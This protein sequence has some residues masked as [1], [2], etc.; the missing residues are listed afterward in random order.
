VR[1]IA[2]LPSLALLS[3]SALGLFLPEPPTLS[4]S[5]GL[6]ASAVSAFWCWRA[7][8][9]RLFSLFVAGAFF[10]GAVLLAAVCWQRAWRPPLR[11]AFEAA[12]RDERAEAARDGR[13]LPLDDEATLIVEG[14]LR[15]DAAPGENGALL[16]VEVDA[17]WQGGRKSHG[18]R[19]GEKL[20]SINVTVVGAL[21]EQHVVD[22]R[23]GRRV[24]MPA[25]LRQPS[26]Y[27]D[28]GVPDYERALA[29]RGVTLVGTV[30]SGALVELVAGGGW[31]NEW[32]ASG[33]AAARGIIA[34]HVGR[35]NPQSA[36][37]VSAIVIGDRS[38]LDAALQRRLQE[39]GTYHVIAISGGN[40]AILAGLLLAVFRIAGLLGRTAMLAAVVLLVVYAQFVGGGASV[41]RATLMAVVYFGARAIDHRGPPLNALAAVA[42]ILVV[43]N[44]LSILDPAFLLTFGATL[45]ILIVVPAVDLRRLPRGT[46]LLASMLVASAAAELLL[47]PIGATVF[48]RVTFAGLGLNFLAIPL[49]GVAQI[50]GMM[51]IPVALVSSPAATAI[52]WV[53][54]AG[55]AGL[56]WS[57]NLVRFVPV[58][59]WRVAAPPLVASAVYYA[60]LATMWWWRRSR[61]VS[62]PLAV[63]AALWILVSPR[64]LFAASGDGRL[65]VTFFDV[66]QGDAMLVVFPRGST[67]LVDAGGLGTTSTFDIGDRVVAPALRAAGIRRLDRV[68]LTHGDG[69]HIGGAASI[70]SEF[71]PR[72]VWEGIP[73]PRS[74]P[75]AVLRTAALEQ[76]GAWANVYSPHRVLIDGV[77]LRAWHPQLEDWE[78]QKVRNDDSI[79]LELQW[80]DVSI[81]LTG[82][83]GREVEQH[84]QAEIP[85]APLR[86]VKVPHHGSLTSSSE[87]F[88]KALQPT[89]AVVS[90]GRTNHFGHPAP[91]VLQRYEAVGA[92]VFRTDR[93]GAVFVESDGS[94]MSVWSFV[95]DAHARI[96]PLVIHEATKARSHESVPMNRVVRP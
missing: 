73:V 63:A 8:S 26:R 77:Q 72:E 61:L 12:A 4:V 59:T 3:G 75:L 20:G 91:E 56:I 96:P 42:A 76:R 68:A 21:A 53:A 54:H 24:R 1:P 74:E 25:Q 89:V 45:A 44:P 67:M 31:W 14:T 69:D 70:I 52:S 29:R 55:A 10:S 36:A 17:L 93:D 5:I 64:A 87:A 39:A 38:S 84:L 9:A 65:H 58:L 57:A 23:A 82:D 18:Q 88:V 37:I 92:K 28:P 60:A 86:V 11:L 48:E 22:W 16:A 15:S 49:M 81:V 46:P 90:A 40:I 78:R 30:K 33:R 50:A 32:L 94:S 66:G 71:K 35:W 43:T 79:V 27:L 95:N 47:L 19:S 34:R 2:A 7:G 62:V 83:I 80:G 13:R 6:T 51:L 41:D 85:P